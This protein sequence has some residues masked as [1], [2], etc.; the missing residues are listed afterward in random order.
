MTEREKKGYDDEDDMNT[1]RQG[2]K[3]GGTPDYEK[4]QS[5]PISDKEF[6]NSKTNWS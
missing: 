3:D 6:D 5:S 2:R 1:Q 4:G